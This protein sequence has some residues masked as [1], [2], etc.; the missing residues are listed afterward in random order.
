MATPF[1]F[2]TP[3]LVI[4][5]ADGRYVPASAFDGTFRE[6]DNVSSV[7]ALPGAG[8]FIHHQ[9]AAFVT[10]QIEAWVAQPPSTFRHLACG[11]RS[12]TYAVRWAM[13]ASA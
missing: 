5:G 1:A 10:Q 8:H 6:V 9:A 3:T 12:S 7:V 4:F 11:R 13:I 2:G